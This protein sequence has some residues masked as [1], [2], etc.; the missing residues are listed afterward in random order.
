[1]APDTPIYVLAGLMIDTHAHRLIVTDEK[2]Q[3]I[4]VVSATDLL[5]VLARPRNYG[6]R[7]DPPY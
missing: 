6:E 7:V 2:R 5:A 1:V 3:P 4:G